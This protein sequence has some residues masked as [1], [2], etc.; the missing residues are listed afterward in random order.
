MRTIGIDVNLDVCKNEGYAMIQYDARKK[1]NPLA[2]YCIFYYLPDY[3]DN[4]KKRTPSFKSYYTFNELLEIYTRHKKD[5]DD[6]AETNKNINFLNPDY[7]DFL[8][9]ASDLIAYCGLG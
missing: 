8:N 9:L 6:F 4:N 1:F 2:E 3:M 7:C 5:I